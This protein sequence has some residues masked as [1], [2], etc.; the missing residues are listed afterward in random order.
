MPNVEPPPPTVPR[1]HPQ[2][3]LARNGRKKG[4]YSEKQIV[5]GVKRGR[6][7]AEDLAWREGL[8]EWVPLSQ[9]APYSLPEPVRL[10]ARVTELHAIAAHHRPILWI[11]AG[12]FFAFAFPPAL[13]ALFVAGP[14]YSYRLA[15]ALR[16]PFPSVYAA[17][18]WMPFLGLLPLLALDRTATRTLQ[19]AGIRVGWVGARWSDLRRLQG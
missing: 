7:G 10:S 13:I 1:S 9:A 5:K 12:M 15:R 17:L 18:A 19:Q 6:Y 16:S 4:P 2:I 8:E 3:Y 14:I 11:V